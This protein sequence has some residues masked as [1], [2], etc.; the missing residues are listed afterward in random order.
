M[1]HFDVVHQIFIAFL[2]SR[3][4]LQIQDTS[5]RKNKQIHNT[6]IPSVAEPHNGGAGF[7]ALTFGNRFY[8]KFMTKPC[9]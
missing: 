7:V 8:G 5:H 6:I 1:E 2:D 9:C 4:V 3:L